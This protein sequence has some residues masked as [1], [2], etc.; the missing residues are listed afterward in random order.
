M[1]PTESLANVSIC[2]K[3]CSA[4]SMPT[5]SYSSSTDQVEKPNKCTI[6]EPK[7]R[8][9]PIVPKQLSSSNS[10]IT[11]KAVDMI[12]NS[13]NFSSNGDGDCNNLLSQLKKDSRKKSIKT[14]TKPLKE[15]KNQEVACDKYYKQEK[16]SVPVRILPK[17]ERLSTE[18]CQI[19]SNI[20]RDTHNLD[21]PP[22]ISI[23]DEAVEMAGIL[24]EN[25]ESEDIMVDGVL[26]SKG[27]GSKNHTV[28]SRTDS[29]NN[30][31]GLANTNCRRISNLQSKQLSTSSVTSHTNSLSSA[32]EN[33]KMLVDF[34]YEQGKL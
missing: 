13:N 30:T 24:N 3:T 16:S 20:M 22:Q 23:L 4:N 5:I 1:Q 12:F 7:S 33:P 14:N 9:I 10:V 2:L 8:Y 11:P 26:P 27:S 32:K 18:Q 34:D 29:C 19:S 25:S 15:R 6:S 28:E 21:N 17:I 31:T